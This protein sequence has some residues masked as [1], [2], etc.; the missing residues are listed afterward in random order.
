MY[1]FLILLK[2]HKWCSRKRDRG[3]STAGE[4]H[5]CESEEHGHW[6]KQRAWHTEQDHWQ[7][8]WQGKVT[9]LI[10]EEWL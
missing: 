7:H 5:Y 6:H 1:A 4:Q 10:S 8:H 2:N 3:E 9:L